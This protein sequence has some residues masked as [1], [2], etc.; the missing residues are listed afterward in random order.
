MNKKFY[1]ALVA[2]AALFASCSSDQIAEAPN[3]D[4]DDSQPVKIGFAIGNVTAGV[5]RTTGSGAVGVSA[6]GTSLSEKWKG[7]SFNVFM[8]EKGTV[9]LAQDENGDAIYDNKKLTT[10]ESTP[11]SGIYDVAYEYDVDGTTIL[12]TYYPGGALANKV[13]DFWA[14]RTDGA[15]KLPYAVDATEKTITV[16]FEID[17]S[18]DVMYATTAPSATSLSADK[19]YTAYSARRGV[20]PTFSFKH[21][22]TRLTFKAIANDAKMVNEENVKI[23]GI[24]VRS[25]KTGALL[26]GKVDATGN[27]DRITWTD[28]AEKWDDATTLTPMILKQ[29]SQG[30]N[31]PEDGTW[32]EV[33]RA[34]AT[35]NGGAGTNIVP[36]GGKTPAFTLTTATKLYAADQ[37]T[38]AANGKPNGTQTTFAD[39][40]GDVLYYWNITQDLVLSGLTDVTAQLDNLEPVALTVSGGS[41]GS[42]EVPVV[43][44]NVDNTATAGDLAT[45]EAANKGYTVDATHTLTLAEWQNTL[46]VA[47]GYVYYDG[48]TYTKFDVTTAYEAAVPATAGTPDMSNFIGESLFLAPADANGYEVTV[49]YQLDKKANSADPATPTDFSSTV[50]IKRTGTD[51]NSGAQGYIPYEAGSTY[52]IKIKLYSDHEVA[53]TTTVEDLTPGTGTDNPDDPNDGA[54]DF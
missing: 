2:T 25:K 46:A 7:Q 18:Q 1:L 52:L 12:Y 26:V 51:P 19:I 47:N 37:R 15:E 49:H 44:A 13:Y 35:A 21:G 54:W 28:A 43:V 45:A 8:L 10:T 50:V 3:L 22:L 16:P 27:E 20:Q 14:Y 4:V 36:P 32:V 5:T 31:T 29:R 42:P 24:E 41:A 33:T 38:Q 39:V 6:D 53:P 11:A 30:V 9:T 40:T 48:T 34:Q 17:G 23:T